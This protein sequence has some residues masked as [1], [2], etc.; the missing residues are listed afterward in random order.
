MAVMGVIP[1]IAGAISAIGAIKQGQAASAAAKFNAKVAEANAAA[2]DQQGQAAAEAQWRDAQRRIGAMTAEYGASGVSSAEGSAAE[3]LADSVRMATLD[4][5]TT[6]Y[7][8]KVR[9][10]GYRAEAS[11]NKMNAKSARTASYFEVAGSLL[12][13]VGSAMPY[14]SGAGSASGAAPTSGT[15]TSSQIRGR[16]LM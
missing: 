10:V 5:L 13:G 12:R 2:A 4:N 3:A 11:L 15:Y 14:F 7:N 9:S 1:I 16:G 8:Y 6:K